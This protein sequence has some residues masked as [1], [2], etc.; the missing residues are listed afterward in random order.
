[1]FPKNLSIGL[2]I[3]AWRLKNILSLKKFS[4]SSPSVKQTPR[5]SFLFEML[6]NPSSPYTFRIS[7]L[8]NTSKGNII[9]SINSLL[10]PYKK[11][12]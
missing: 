6:V 11:K 9:L 5:L 1:M 7:I 3:I 2:N 12:D 4:I 8:Y 10:N